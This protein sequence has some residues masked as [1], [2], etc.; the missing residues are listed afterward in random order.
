MKKAFAIMTSFLVALLCFGFLSNAS[1]A[2]SSESKKF[3]EDPTL[4]ED[5]DPIYIMNSIYTTFPNYYDNEKEPDPVWKGVSRMYPWNET[6]LRIAQF[7][8]DGTQSG[9]YYAIFF[10]GENKHMNG[11]DPLSGAGKNILV[12]A[13]DEAGNLE[14]GKFSEGKYYGNRNASD[15]SL[16]HMNT[17]IT[18]EDI[19]FDMIQLFEKVGDSADPGRMMNQMLVFD[20]QGRA[21]RGSVGNSVFLAPGAEG[22]AEYLMAPVFCYVD[23]KVVKYVEGETI[24]DKLKEPVLNPETGEQEVDPETGEPLMQETDKDAFFY[25]RFTW[26]W[27]Q[28]KP[29]NVNEVGYLEEGW[30]KDSWDYC[31]GDEESGYMCYAFMDSDGKEETLDADMYVAYLREWEKEHQAQIAAGTHTC[32][33]EKPE[34]KGDQPA[35]DGVCDSTPLQAAVTR[36]VITEFYIPAGGWT[37]D[38]G[39]LDKQEAILSDFYQMFLD[40]YHYGRMEG[41]GQQTTHNFSVSGLIVKDALTEANEGL[42]VMPGNII[43]I[44]PGTVFD[45]T[46]NITYTGLTKYWEK[47]EDNSIN[48]VT[49]FQADESV[50]E[51]YVKINGLTVVMPNKYPSYAA[52]VEDFMNDLNT[53][54]KAKHVKAGGAEEAYVPVATPLASY[55]SGSDNDW[56]S[57]VNN[58]IA[59]TNAAYESFIKNDEMWA[60]WQWFFEYANSKL[61]ADQ[62]VNINDRVA[63][64]SPGHFTCTMAGLLTQSPAASG[65][66]SAKGDFTNAEKETLS[67]PKWGE[68]LVDSTGAELDSEYVVEYTV[69]NKA[70]GNQ[71]TVV[72]TYKVTDVYTPILEQKAERIEAAIKDGKLVINNGNPILA[73]DLV[74]AYNG[75]YTPLTGTLTKDVKGRDITYRTTIESDTLDFNNPTSGT[76]RVTARVA[77]SATKQAVLQFTITIKDLTAPVAEVVSDTLY[78]E[79]GSIFDPAVGVVAAS[80]DVDG[81]LKLA[82]FS[83]CVDLSKTPVNTTKPGN[84]TVEVGIYDKAGNNRS[85]SYKVVV[86]AAP[87]SA[88]DLGELEDIAEENGILISELQ[89]ALNGLIQQVTDL[90]SSKGGCGKSTGALAVSLLSAASL[91]VLVLRKKH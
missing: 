72:V 30:D 43:E 29:E 32:V 89:E 25:K 80:D 34:A 53:F 64:G 75:K 44:M 45:P 57:R 24:P 81:N 88:E 31:F 9:R 66:P 26:A 14:L 91:L 69:I 13:Y 27:F 47:G 83:W 12:Y 50:C 78:V 3:T 39:F 70:T 65:W 67:N 90:A 52:L 20:A 18:G 55:T 37:Y 7:N 85:Y 82:P 11:N 38:F 22:A 51:F 48:D 21:I 23:G 40:A 41:F 54:L 87:A 2:A 33:D 73:S 5:E 76:H 10:N 61:P 49:K 58:E 84:Y 71:D 60:K 79:Y 62:A 46:D 59:T 63:I 1:V 16:S 6:R 77:N 86:T 15:P 35:G 4:A 19:T 56:Y 68:Y 74:V 28:T 42:R 36:K 17:N 8:D